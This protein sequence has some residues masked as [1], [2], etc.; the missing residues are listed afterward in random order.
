MLQ[1]VLVHVYL[2][3]ATTKI[4]QNIHKYCF[5]NSLA[6]MII[7]M[8]AFEMLEKVLTNIKSPP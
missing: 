8:P 2:K 6:E 3:T 7:K 4:K 5:E 1:N